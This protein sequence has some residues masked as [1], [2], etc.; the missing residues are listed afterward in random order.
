MDTSGLKGKTALVTGAAR[1][2]GA[3]FACVL[4]EAGC[5]VIMTGRSDR[6]AYQH[7]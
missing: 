7:G 3:A 2:L 1:G 6:A 5:N 4:A